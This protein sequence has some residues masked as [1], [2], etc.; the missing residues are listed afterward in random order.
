MIFLVLTVLQLFH[1]LFTK[2]KYYPH[3]PE[4]KTIL[5][6]FCQRSGKSFLAQKDGVILQ[7]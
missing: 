5:D 2:G 7:S 4:E 1:F 3:F 6:L